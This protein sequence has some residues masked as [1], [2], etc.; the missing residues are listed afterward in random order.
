MMGVKLFVGRL[1]LQ[2]DATISKS[3]PAAKSAV[4]R[5]ALTGGERERIGEVVAGGEDSVAKTPLGGSR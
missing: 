1:R 2:P 3:W 5:G 4:M